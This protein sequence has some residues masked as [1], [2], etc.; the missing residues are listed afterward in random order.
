[1]GDVV[2]LDFSQ[3]KKKPK[4]PRIDELVPPMWQEFAAKHN[5]EIELTGSGTSFFIQGKPFTTPSGTKVEPSFGYM[6]PTG[7]WRKQGELEE[8]QVVC[9]KTHK[10]AFIRLELLQPFRFIDSL[11]DRE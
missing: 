8:I 5:L 11:E 6:R 9:L 1:M 4:D 7:G 10:T 3:K 2:Y